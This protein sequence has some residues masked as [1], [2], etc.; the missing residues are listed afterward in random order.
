MQICLATTLTLLSL[1]YLELYLFSDSQACTGRHTHTHRHAFSWYLNSQRKYHSWDAQQERSERCCA[2]PGT[3]PSVNSI[4][5][6]ILFTYTQTANQAQIEPNFEG[7]QPWEC[8][9]VAPTA[10]LWGLWLQSTDSLTLID[11]FYHGPKEINERE[12]GS[13]ASSTQQKLKR[14]AAML[15]KTK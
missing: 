8:R 10:N 11:C 13:R 7:A 3:F 12:T 5:D 1:R 9:S 6:C 2:Q 15:S 14:L 4:Q